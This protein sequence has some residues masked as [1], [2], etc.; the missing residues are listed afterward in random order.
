VNSALDQGIPLTDAKFMSNIDL[1]SFK[2]MFTADDGSIIPLAEERV[3][4]IRE[5]GQILLDIYQG[6]FYNS[7]ANAQNS[8]KKLLSTIVRD[9]PSFRD[10]ASFKGESVSFLKRAQIL[11]ADI[12]SCFKGVGKELGQFADIADLTMFADYRV[13]QALAFLGVLCYSDEVIATLRR[14][15]LLENGSE[16]EMLIRGYSIYACDKIVEKISLK[17]TDRENSAQSY[18]RINAVDVDVWLWLFRR[19]N[20][21]QIEKTTPFHRCR[22]I[23]Y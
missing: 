21:E 4:V 2:E 17:M 12:H 13:P 15:N 19:S 1:E 5:A 3:R 8:A 22:C 9:F 11:V 7:V 16:L 6:S 23:Y 20:S 18:N 14:N 10:F